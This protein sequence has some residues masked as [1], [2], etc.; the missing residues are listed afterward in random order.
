MTATRA[1]AALLGLLALGCGGAGTRTDGGSRDAGESGADANGGLC[2]DFQAC[3]GD[4]VGTWTIDP[5]CA[6]P[7]SIG[8]S[9]C[10][11]QVFDASRVIPQ[12]TWMFAAN[13]SLTLTI[14]T[15]GTLT[16]RTP[17][18]CLVQATGAPVQCTS[19]GAGASY[20]GRVTFEGAK[21]GVATCVETTGTCTCSVP[22][23]AAPATDDATYSVANATITLVGTA[24]S[25]V[26]CV[27]G[28]TLKLRPSTDGGGPG[29][30][31]YTRGP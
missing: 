22:I 26:Y 27:S 21:T 13:G 5:R 12:A 19:D 18:A 10:A 17:D 1:V 11:G 24:V 8:S 15:A 6:P 20:A 7:A 14:S 29:V 28:T 9:E 4:L 31:V 2:T 25:Y 23:V 30:A 3:G 16:V